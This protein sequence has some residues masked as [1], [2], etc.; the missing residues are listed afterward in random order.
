MLLRRVLSV[1]GRLL[2]PRRAEQQLDDELQ[3]FLDASTADKIRG[4][5]SP[6]EARRLALVELGGVE[7]AKERVRTYQRGA[8][9]DEIS[10]D[11][12][13]AIR[14]FARNPGFTLV[15][16]L[17]LTLGIGAN[18]AIFGLI[19]ALM[20][21]SLPVRDP[22]RLVQISIGSDATTGPETLSYPIVGVLAAQREIFAGVAGFNTA[23]F[24]TGVPGNVVKV[25][26]ALVTGGF[27]ETLGLE[28]V[29]GRLIAP[30]DDRPGAPLVAVL[31]FGYWDRQFDRRLDIAGQS[32]RLNGVPVTIVGVSP[33][34]FTG[35]DVGS[36]AD[37]TVPV[38]ALPQLDPPMAMLLGPGNFWLRVLARP[39]PGVSNEQT[40]ARLTAMWPRISADAIP[41]HWPVSRQKDLAGSTFRARPGGTGFTFLRQ[42]YGTALLVLMAVVGLVLLIACAN[43]ASLLLARASSRRRE[44]ALRLALGAGRARVVRQL[45]IE[46]VLLSSAGAALGTGLAWLSSRFLVSMISTGPTGLAFDLSPNLRVLT[47]TSV[48]T[49]ATALFFGVAPAVQATAIRPA[50]ALKE[51]NRMSRTRSRLLPSLVSGQVALSLV[52]LVC[53]GLFGRTLQNLRQFDSGFDSENVLL[54]ELPTSSSIALQQILGAVRHVPDVT[55]ASLSTHTP[56]S[57]STWSEPAVPAGQP[58]PDRDTALFVGAS[59]RYF[60]TLR[61]QVLAGRAFADDDSGAAPAVA[62]VNQ[63]FA[64]KFF[65]QQNPIGQHLAASIRGQKGTLVVVG[66]TKNVSATGLRVPPVPMVYV[67]LAQ[68][69]ADTAATLEVRAGRDTARVSRDVREAIRANLP[70]ASVEVRSL[71]SQVDDTMLQERMLATLTGAFGLLALGLACIGLYGLLAYG[72]AQRIREIGIR[73]ALGAQR[74]GVTTMVLKDAVWL[75]VAG[76]GVGLPAAWMAS[77]SVA[78]LLFELTPGDPTAIVGGILAL[79]TAALLAAY[80]PARRASRVDPLIALRHE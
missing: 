34:R 30:A 18:T 73:L 52:L 41:A 42:Q 26:G 47:F 50:P 77:R 56:L 65:P 12:R 54:S 74:R 28:P 25:P 24:D 39:A 49:I 59:P 20:L 15:I 78:S 62:I 57:G 71:V 16:V 27:Y 46:S 9:I 4:G 40:A 21:R 37:I 79:T 70:D 45:L 60:E 76:V 51:D 2:R 23:T 72:V 64:D 1:A 35:A 5:M 75:V 11:V 68:L 80:G 53:A 63:R 61:I 48:V 14:M 17:T 36:I 19:D 33:R 8:W 31:S 10:R 7:Q 3:E 38:A 43:V 32:I 29:A 13:Y 67:P 55:S 58:I 66:L 44:I 6:G 69:P 22:Q